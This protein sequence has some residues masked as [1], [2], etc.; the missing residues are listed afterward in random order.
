[1]IIEGIETSQVCK[2]LGIC[3]AQQ[4]ELLGDSLTSFKDAINAENLNPV[5][6]MQ[7]KN[8]NCAT[9]NYVVSV[10]LE[11]VRSITS[12]FKQELDCNSFLPFKNEISACQFR[13]YLD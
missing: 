10:V 12:Q 2:L 5:V 6:V 4:N 1:M 11:Q 9:C 8:E 7:K 13:F 3:N